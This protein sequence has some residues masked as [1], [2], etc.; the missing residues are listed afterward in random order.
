M[1]GP[2]RIFTIILFALLPVF[3]PATSNAFHKPLCLSRITSSDAFVV[4]GPE[5]HILYKKHENK[6]LIPASTI[7]ILTALTAIRYLGISYR[8]PTEFYVDT[9]QNLKMKGYGDPLLISEVW[10]QI[11]DVLAKK[12]TRFNGLVLDDTY[13]SGDIEIPGSGRSTNP[14]DA[15]VAALC[16]NFNTVFFDKDPQGKIV[17]AEPQTPM[18][19][20]AR[21]KVASLKL[22]GG[23]HVFSHNP[24]DAARYSGDLLLHLLRNREVRFSGEVS[25]GTVEPG[26]RLIYTYVSVFS[27]EQVLAKMLTFSSNFMANQILIALGAQ[28]HGPPGTLGKGIRVLKTYTKS[29]LQLQN[30]EISEGSGISRKNRISAM[31][32]LTILKA[33]KPYRTLLKKQDH[34]LYKT[35][36]L[37]G[38]SNLVGYLKPSEKETITFVIFLNRSC[39]EMDRLVECMRKAAAGG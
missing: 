5:S 33:F 24:K 10:Q 30:I 27:L 20:Y 19:D 35:G 4:A 25:F 1:T 36:T 7:K 23:R 17:S 18:T 37:R 6:K 39:M 34:L 13:F 15:P 26:D 38:I 16:T 14:F 9:A 22:K 31:D 12:V 8:F 3:E 11:A 32:M 2:P 28:V 29:E 21:E